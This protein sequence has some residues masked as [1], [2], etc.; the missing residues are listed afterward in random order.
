MSRRRSLPCIPVDPLE[1]ETRLLFEGC[2]RSRAIVV[3]FGSLEIPAA[4]QVGGEP[5]PVGSGG[6]EVRLQLPVPEQALPLG[7]DDHH[8]PGR[9][10]PESADSRRRDVHRSRLGGDDHQVVGSDGQ[11]RG[12][13]PVAVEARPH[14]LAVAEGDESRSVPG[15]HERCVKLV[16]AAQFGRHG[17]VALPG[18]RNHHREGMGERTPGVLQQLEHV[19]E[20]RGIAA[21]A[22]HHRQQ[23]VE[24]RPELGRCEEALAG[25]KRVQIAPQGVDLSVVGDEAVGVGALPARKSVGAETLVCDGER[26]R[27]GLVP[28]VGIEAL[29]LPGQQQPLVDDGPGREGAG[30]ER[31]AGGGPRLLHVPFNHPPQH[32][33][34]SL[35]TSSLQSRRGDKDL[36]D[37]GQRPVCNLPAGGCIDR[38]VPPAEHPK[39][40]RSH[41]L[42]DQAE[43]GPP[44]FLV[45]GKEELPHS[46]GARAREREFQTR[47]RGKECVRNLD[48]NTAA[49]AGL[50]IEARRAAV[51]HT[52]EQTDGEAHDLARLPS[53]ALGDEPDPA[54]ISL[55][56]RPVEARLRRRSLGCGQAGRAHDSVNRRAG[57]DPG[58]STSPHC[59]AIREAQRVPR[60][61]RAPPSSR[62]VP[63]RGWRA[64]R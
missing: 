36:D 42:F 15:L 59:R 28:E 3:P 55:E 21:V 39:A 34:P 6:G 13:K 53:P 33:E 57:R 14:L 45:A 56:L 41:R 48:Q 51:R 2:G 60:W 31:A 19:V 7:V 58:A 4:H 62:C 9:Q 47:V 8:S 50:R 23:L 17:P 38:H 54:G 29:D 46:I 30:I 12:P 5:L 1:P 20:H 49:V 10:A 63:H 32:I 22:V 43:L 37:L 44:C 16:E 61:W 25:T 26:A 11:A 40:F 18:L 52:V 24:V 27:E 35:Q 64:W